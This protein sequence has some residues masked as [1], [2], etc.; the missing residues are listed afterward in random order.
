M[1][2]Q[3]ANLDF[4]QTHQVFFASGGALSLLSLQGIF[5]L[6]QKHNM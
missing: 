1:V 5:N 2:M 4:S 3:L 6:I